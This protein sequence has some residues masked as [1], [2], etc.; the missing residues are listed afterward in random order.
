MNFNKVFIAGN[1]TKDPELRYTNSGKAVA[2]MTVAVNEYGSK[3]ASFFRVVVWEKQAENAMKYLAKGK[4]VFVEGRLKTRGYEYEGQ[5]RII[6]EVM[7]ISVHY[8]YSANND[9]EKQK[10]RSST[11]RLNQQ[12]R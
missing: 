6:T 8:L 7:A 11:N 1:L 5:K 10:K 2:T 4:P 3:D 9:H 12:K